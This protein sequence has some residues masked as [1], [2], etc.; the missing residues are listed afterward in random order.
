MRRCAFNVSGV[1]GLFWAAQWRPD[2]DPIGNDRL[3]A[4]STACRVRS[5]MQ[6]ILSRLSWPSTALRLCGWSPTPGE[7]VYTY[8]MWSIG[9]DRWACRTV[10]EHPESCR[11]PAGAFTIPGGGLRVRFIGTYGP[12]DRAD[13]TSVRAN[14]ADRGLAYQP[15]SPTMR[16]VH[17]WT[18]AP[19]VC[20]PLP[21]PSASQIPEPATVSCCWPPHCVVCRS[22]R[23]SS[24][25][26]VE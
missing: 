7:D 15:N 25:I 1:S 23:R 16:L 10:G 24:P 8:Q 4:T 6:Y 9:T 3:L 18:A 11:H 22:L 21:T 13:C 5:I 17:L 14:A 20:D 2:G 26:T 12:T 19:G